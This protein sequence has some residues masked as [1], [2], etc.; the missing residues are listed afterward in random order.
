[1]DPTDLAL[2]DALQDEIPLVSRP[3]AAIAARLDIPEEEV[4]QRLNGLQER[5]IVR[6]LSPVIESRHA[7][8]SATTL[9]ALRVPDDRI[10]VVARLINAYP[11]VSH[12]YRR[13]HRYSLWF[14]LAGKD[15]RRI[16]EIVREIGEEAGISDEDILELPTVRRFKI[17][18]RFSFPGRATLE[19]ENGPG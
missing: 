3:F 8:L 18:V 6:S 7:G 4:M 9:V 12:N 2:L 5:G 16:R 17:D 15:K 13:D 19:A 11:E 14:T 10:P 1:M